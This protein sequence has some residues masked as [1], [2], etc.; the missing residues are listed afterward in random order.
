MAVAP[1]AYEAPRWRGLLS[2]GNGANRAY[3]TQRVQ[4]WVI[5]GR[6]RNRSPNSV[7]IGMTARLAT[8]SG[9]SIG[10]QTST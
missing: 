4:T 7:A 5:L 6:E 10:I 3:W 2:L 8:H 9:Q 1:F